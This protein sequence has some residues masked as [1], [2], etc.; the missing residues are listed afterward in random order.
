MSNRTFLSIGGLIVLLLIAVVVVIVVGSVGTASAREYVITIPEG[1]GDMIDAGEDPGIIPGDIHLTLGERDILVIQNN[2]VVGHRISDF[3]V[4]AGETF[5][6][7]FHTAAVYQG[8]CT[9]HENARIQIIVE[10]S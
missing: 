3:W 4:G 10:E 1:T 2:D 9:I 8:D 5:R 7:E 6:Q